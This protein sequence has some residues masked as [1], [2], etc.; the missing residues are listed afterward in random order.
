MKN[1]LIPLLRCPRCGEDAPFDVNPAGADDEEVPDGRL[2]CRHCRAAFPVIAGIPRFADSDQNYSENFGIQWKL[3]RE[4]QIDRL[5]GHQLSE[6]RFIKDTRWPAGWLKGKLILDAGCGAGRFTDVMAEMGATVVACDLS[7][8]VEACKK[9][10]DDPTG[11]TAERGRVQPVQGDLLSL[12]FREGVFDAVFCMGVIQHTPDPER[13]IGT[14]PRHLKPGGRLAY[15]FYEIDPF[16]KF[17]FIKYLL[18]RAPHQIGGRIGCI[19]F[20]AG[21]ADSFS[22]LIG[23][24]PHSQGTIC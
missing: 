2:L 8:A 24:M 4:T 23:A 16:T 22:A 12:P 5:A 10:T 14:L 15:N 7:S 6:T 13:V 3:F 19:P 1:W 11:A 21:S 9:T 17:Q 20:A 18:R